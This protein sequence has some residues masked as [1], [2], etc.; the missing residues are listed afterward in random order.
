MFDRIIKVV[1]TPEELQIYQE[2]IYQVYCQ[3][4]KWFEP[5]KYPQG[6]VADEFDSQ[7]KHFLMIDN[8]SKEVMAVMRLIRSAPLPLPIFS[9]FGEQR[10][11]PDFFQSHHCQPTRNREVEIS[12]VAALKKFRERQ[13]S[14]TVDIGKIVYQ[15]CLQ[16]ELGYMYFTIDFKFF[17]E[18]HK[19][20]FWVEPIGTPRFYYGSWVLPCI[21]FFEMMANYLKKHNPQA[22]DYAINPNNLVGSFKDKNLQ[23]G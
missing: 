22:F 4:L 10:L 20:D 2:L 9:K 7:S 5:E 21:V 1:E 3:E 8:Q 12:Q 13:M 23:N 6:R 11:A 17:L 19:H 16:N 14:F 15:S 18:A